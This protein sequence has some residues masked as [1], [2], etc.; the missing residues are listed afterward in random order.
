MPKLALLVEGGSFFRGKRKCS[1]LVDDNDSVAVASSK[2]W[3]ALDMAAQASE[4]NIE[5]F[6]AQWDEFVVFEERDQ[7]ANKV[8]LRLASNEPQASAS[9]SAPVSDTPT[10]TAPAPAPAPAEDSEPAQAASEPAVASSTV[11]SVCLCD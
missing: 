6:D 3:D 2:I 5:I 10:E 7:L 11:R 4:G 9:S 1:V 8:K